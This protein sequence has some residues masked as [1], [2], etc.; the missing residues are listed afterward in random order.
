[1]KALDTNVLVRFLVADDKAQ[2]EA[3]RDLL[4]QAETSGRP[5]FVPLP[6]MLELIW[7]L[8]SAYEVPREQLIE[9]I[10]KM[11]TMPALN[12]EAHEAVQR[13]V[14]SA[15]E[16]QAGLADLLIAHA[17]IGAGCKTVLTFDKRAART[18]WF[19]LL[20]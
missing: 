7:V 11:L 19:T 10:Q 15:R 18:R 1:M 17:A 13:M 5:L 14:D 6:V 2:A 8:Q 9:S 3:A 12:F 20:E 16:C 4:R